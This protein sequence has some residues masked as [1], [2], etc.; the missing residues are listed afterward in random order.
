MRRFT[1][2]VLIVAALAALGG[3]EAFR[4]SAGVGIG[5][6]GSVRAGPADVGV[7]GGVSYEWGNAYGAVGSQVTADIGI[8]VARFEILKDSTTRGPRGRGFRGPFRAH[9]EG[10]VADLAY[11]MLG[12]KPDV[13][14]YLV[15]RP[16]E[17]A[18]SVYAVFL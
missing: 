11:P 14:A 2:R 10:L 5:L 9:I 16:T 4:A 13:R 17:L 6:G 1:G 15:N 12:D 3:C 18:V 8:A 7:L